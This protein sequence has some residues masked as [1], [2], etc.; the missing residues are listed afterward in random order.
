[1]DVVSYLLGKNASGGGANL[2]TKSVS[3]TENGETSVSADE[4]YDG[5]EQVNITT[6]VPAPK[7]AP[8]YIRFDNYTGTSLANEINN[9][10]GT[11]LTSMES[12]FSNCSNITSINL[13]NFDTSNVTNM[14]ETFNYCTS[15]SN[16][17]SNN[18]NTSK[19]TSFSRCF[20]QC[21]SL[22]QLDL[23]E[24]V[25]KNAY[26]T[27][28][29]QGC[30]NLSFLDVRNVE[31]N[32]AQNYDYMFGPNGDVP[33]SCLIIVKDDTQKAWMYNHFRSWTNVKTAAE[34][35]ASL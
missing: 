16:L 28:M 14:V 5:L 35:E 4:G 34:Y 22:Q 21:T 6:N 2:Q 24:W 12:M 26:I 23:S 25:I 11:N 7:Y 27:Q 33:K 9:L 10:S 17:S 30:R 19:V 15:L 32:T 29:F 13:D 20:I 8:R 18:I 31:F 3:I 1:M